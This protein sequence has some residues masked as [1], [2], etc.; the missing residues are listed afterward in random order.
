MSLFFIS[1][2]SSS[3]SL[4]YQVQFQEISD[5]Y[6]RKQ[7]QISSKK[8]TDI[9]TYKKFLYEVYIYLLDFILHRKKCS[10]KFNVLIT[11]NKYFGLLI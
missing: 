6:F 1:S 10:L 5:Q 7:S 2:K 11:F 4:K 8:S 9:N 3:C